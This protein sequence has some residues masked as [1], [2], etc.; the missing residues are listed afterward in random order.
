[1]RALAP[2]V[3]AFPPDSEFFWKLFSRAAEYPIAEAFSP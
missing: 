2:E 3:L 1:M